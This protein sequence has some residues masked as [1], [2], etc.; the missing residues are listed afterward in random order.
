MRHQAT[1]IIG[2]SQRNQIT[3]SCGHATR[4]SSIAGDMPVPL[5]SLPS[6]VIDAIQTAFDQTTS[7]EVGPDER[8]IVPITAYPHWLIISATTE[9]IGIYS[10]LL[11][12]IIPYRSS[13]RSSP[14]IRLSFAQHSISSTPIVLYLDLQSTPIRLIQRPSCPSIPKEATT[15]TPPVSPGA[16][17]T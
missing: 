16:R 12:S 9:L 17:P 2:P 14:S 6:A 3:Y 7:L 10:L 1:S 4:C 8:C 13:H 5:S 11:A 15:A